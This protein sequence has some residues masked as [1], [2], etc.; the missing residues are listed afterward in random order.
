MILT[1][2]G[3]RIPQ[4]GHTAD[5]PSENPY[6]N[7]QYGQG[8]YDFHPGRYIVHR[9][10]PSE[11]DNGNIEPVQYHTQHGE[12]GSEPD[13]EDVAGPVTVEKKDHGHKNKSCH[14][15]EKPVTHRGVEQVPVLV[16]DENQYLKEKVRKQGPG[17]DF[18]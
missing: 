7:E 5:H 12:D 3:W 13:H 8:D 10:I 9:H 1:D 4:D 14:F 16:V 11:T 6:F 15:E 18:R 2:P 17:T